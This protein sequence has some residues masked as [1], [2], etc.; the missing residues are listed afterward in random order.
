MTDSV[1]EREADC[2]MAFLEFMSMRFR[3]IFKG[4]ED[5]YRGEAVTPVF[6]TQTHSEAL[7]KNQKKNQKKNL[8]VLQRTCAIREEFS[9][10]YQVVVIFLNHVQCCVIRNI[11]KLCTLRTARVTT[12]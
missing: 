11:F 3:S 6:A 4:N 8:N 12:V 9:T 10:S 5:R 2:T 7:F 1:T